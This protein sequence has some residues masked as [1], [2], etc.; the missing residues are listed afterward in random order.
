VAVYLLS[1]DNMA[2]PPAHLAGDGGLLA[3][4]GDLSVP[5][6]LA[7]Y[8]AGIFPWY[9][10]GEPILWWSPDP[11]LVLYPNE[12]IVSRRL[13]RTIRQGRFGITF[14]A[15]F[16]TVI[17]ACADMPRKGMAGTW[18]MP[19]MISAYCDLHIAGWAHSVEAWASGALAGGVYG[20]S[21]GGCFFGESMFSRVSNASKVA[22]FHLI[23]R[24]KTG[25]CRL[26]DCQV[27]SDHLIRLGAREIPRKRFLSE[28][29]AA[30]GQN[31]EPGKWAG[32]CQG[33]DGIGV[34]A[35]EG[36]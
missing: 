16:E 29:R 24:L 33:T 23:E 1:Q 13:R 12:L 18:I 7:A 17:R 30:V 10:A 8:A 36:G 27:S 3:V 31:I 6:L 25:G 28:M 19:E 20:V 5:R 11:R 26:V 34:K 2:F 15:A 32:S 4:G 35:D 9:A 14:D 22:L 21:I